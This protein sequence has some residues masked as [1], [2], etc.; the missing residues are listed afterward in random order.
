MIETEFLNCDNVSAILYAPDIPSL[1]CTTKYFVHNKRKIGF[2]CLFKYIYG[3][4]SYI[5]ASKSDS[6]PLQLEY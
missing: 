1:I 5:S 2:I 3:L 6:L 4:T